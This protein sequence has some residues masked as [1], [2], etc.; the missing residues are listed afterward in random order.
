MVTSTLVNPARLHNRAWSSRRL[1]LPA[2]SFYLTLSTN[3]IIGTVAGT[4]IQLWRNP[5]TWKICST[6]VDFVKMMLLWWWLGRNNIATTRKTPPNLD[7]GRPFK[8]YTQSD[9]TS[10]YNQP[11]DASRCAKSYEAS[12]CTQS[13]EASQIKRAVVLNQM[14]RVVTLSQMKR[15]VV[16]SQMKQVK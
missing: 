1:F 8:R 15:V 12:R 5:A 16:L 13:N 2:I 11:N 10:R 3:F 4:T 7:F 6:S 14:R 9:E